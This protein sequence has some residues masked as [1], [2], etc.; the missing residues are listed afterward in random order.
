MTADTPWTTR[1]YH[2][3]WLMNQAER[4]F[5]LF[6]FNAVNP[7]GGFYDLDATGKPFGSLRQIHV[8]GRMVHCF[9]IGHKLGRPGCDAIVDHGMQFLWHGHRDPA[10]GGYCWSLDDDG[11][12][13]DSKQAYGHA[14]VLLAAAV[15]YTA[16]LDLIRVVA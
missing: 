1:P 12:K 10:Y 16:V 6:Q 14:F 2:R 13:D 7:K 8:T 4:Q 15:H 9:A 5:D 11:F 3:Q